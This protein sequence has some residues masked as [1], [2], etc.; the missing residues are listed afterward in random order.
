MTS[1]PCMTRPKTLK[2]CQM[3]SLWEFGTLLH[4]HMFSRK[5]RCSSKSD[6]PLRPVRIWSTVSHDK[7]SDRVSIPTR[8]RWANVPRLVDLCSLALQT[9]IFKH[10]PV[11]TLPTGPIP[12][13][14]V[15]RLDHKLVND[16]VNNRVLVVER[17]VR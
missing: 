12:F 14:K 15:S 17:D 16:T 7:E 4:L 6:K 8:V 1:K 9:L 10:A 13:G 3:G 11:D 2:V 5:M